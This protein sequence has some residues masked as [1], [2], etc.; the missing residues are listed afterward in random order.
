MCDDNKNNNNFKL[1]QSY[2]K[3]VEPIYNPKPLSFN[4]DFNI[5]KQPISQE[6]PPQIPQEHLSKIILNHTK[7]ITLHKHKTLSQQVDD[8]HFFQAEKNAKKRMKKGRF[9]F[10][11]KIDLHGQTQEQ[12]FDNLQKF[13]TQHYKNQIRHLLVITGRGRYCYTTLAS[14]GILIKKVPQWLSSP[15]F[16]TMISVIEQAS[17]YDG[18][19]GALYIVL[20]KIT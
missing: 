11:A 8:K 19:E 3:G 7:P 15:P 14:S 10:G 18:G 5:D 1:W 4:M 17:A 2:I 16:S 12:A 6:T 9:V 13:I 20:R